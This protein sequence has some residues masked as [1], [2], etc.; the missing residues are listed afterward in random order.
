MSRNANTPQY[1]NL[2]SYATPGRVY[3]FSTAPFVLQITFALKTAF[4]CVLPLRMT[5][6]I[7]Y[8][9]RSAQAILFPLEMP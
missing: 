9:L 8:E 4:A 5:R 7:P 1:T 3:Q 2:P 6:A